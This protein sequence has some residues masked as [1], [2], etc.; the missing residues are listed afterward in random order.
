MVLVFFGLGA[1]FIL[2]VTQ[3]PEGVGLTGALSL[4][5]AAHKLET[6][7]FTFDL[8]QTY[9]FWSGLLGGLFL[10]LSYFG[11]DQSQVQRFLTARSVDAGRISLLMSAFVKIPIQFLILLIGV[12]VFVSYQFQP[13]PLLFHPQKVAELSTGP[14]AGRFAELQRRHEAARQRL[15]SSA[16]ALARDGQS[17]DRL[18]TYRQSLDESTRVRAQ[19]LELARESDAGFNDVNYIFPSFILN[20]LPVGLVGLMI[21]AVFA[22]AMSSVAAELNALATTTVT[23]FY[24]RFFRPR[25]SEAHYLLVSRFVTALWGIIA[26]MVAMY[27][28]NLGSLIEVVNV[29]GSFFYGS[30]LGVFVLAVGIGRATS[31]GAFWGLLAGMGV[32]AFVSSVSS[33]SFLW[34]NVVGTVTVV[35]TGWVISLLSPSSSE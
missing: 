33:V 34:Y 29:F 26:C 30:I 10:M 27:A 2:I 22:A 19:G 4:A 24:R 6:I 8:S 18:E 35:A 20:N 25:H 13:V 23:D 7:D 15:E 11:C 9:T 1:C 5:G 14:D 32:V 21:A 28:I 12:L 3:L 17:A 31:T 16:L